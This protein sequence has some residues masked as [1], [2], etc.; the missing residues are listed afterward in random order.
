MKKYTLNKI[1]E[2]VT[3][4]KLICIL[5]LAS[6]LF[7]IWQ[8]STG[9]SWD[10]IS[11]KLNAQYI[12]SDGSYFEWY[13][14][15]LMPFLLGIFSLFGWKTA[16]YLFIISV[17]ILYL[18]ACLKFA[19]NF[20]IDKDIFYAISLTPFL[21]VHSFS[22]GTE[23]LSFSLVVLGI[24][25]YERS[26][27][28]FFFGLSYLAKSTN[29]IYAPFMFIGK[30]Y[31]KILLCFLF[32]SLTVLPWLIYNYVLT[33]N[34]FTNFM[35]GYA[36]QVKFRGYMNTPF[37]FK[38]LVI[39]GNYLLLFGLFGLIKKLKEIKSI[40]FREKRFVEF[41]IIILFLILTLYAYY[42]VPLK[43]ER[44]LF[45]IVL[46]LAYFSTVFLVKINK[47]V[48]YAIILFS[49][50]A[51]LVIPVWKVRLQDDSL[52]K[53]TL[54]ETRMLIARCSLQSNSWIYLNNLG[55]LT[56]PAPDKRIIIHK[57]N[58]GYKILLFNNVEEP[59]YTYDRKF[60]ESLPIIK[61][62]NDY[63]LIGMS[64]YCK[65]TTTYHK[66][67][68]ENIGE[69]YRVAFNESFSINLYELLFTDKTA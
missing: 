14:P 20:K 26:S 6:T 21:I 34:P 67:Y 64:D 12:F 19:D 28:G 31:K 44:Y 53:Q 40:N 61:K 62:T 57:L 25:Y 60:I 18:F 9:V 10:F 27:S 54:E 45:N 49:F 68:L 22:V 37:S 11:Y 65:Q 56:E 4:N 55:R 35:D 23:L 51:L 15:P 38:D 50:V 1:F 24:A 16:E 69:L 42:H 30:S 13:R 33:G 2:T 5:F 47:K 48:V 41:V 66:T 3:E 63:V 39:A 8:H 7:F 29:L 59:D 58:E 43:I 52:Y 32:Y 46:P 17:S 36:S